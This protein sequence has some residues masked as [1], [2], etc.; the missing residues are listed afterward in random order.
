MTLRTFLPILIALSASVACAT[1][2]EPRVET[3]DVSASGV[4]GSS[5]SSTVS[6]GGGGGSP[7][8]EAVVRQVDATY[9]DFEGG[10]T[11]VVRSGSPLC[12]WG[13]DVYGQLADGDPSVSYK[14]VSITA[15][16]TPVDRLAVGELG[17][18]CA[19]GSDRAVYCWGNNVHGAAGIGA[20]SDVVGSPAHVAELGHEVVALSAGESACAIR[21]GGTLWCWGYS[22]AGQLGNGSKDPAFAPTQVVDLPPVTAVSTRAGAAC[23][24]DEAGEVW[25]WGNNAAGQLGIGFADYDEHTT[26][27][28]VETLGGGV[29]GISSGGGHVCARKNDDKLWCWGGNFGVVPVAAPDLAAGVAEAHAGY[30]FTC[31]LDREGAAWCWGEGANGQLGDGAGTASATPVQVTALGHDVVDLSSGTSSS[32]A[33][34]RDGSVWCWGLVPTTTEEASSYL[35]PTLLPDDFACSSETAPPL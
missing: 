14:A 34:K 33:T 11:C 3:D 9:N 8:V 10:N 32:C 2:S 20:A 12:C 13:S 16:A 28:K 7:A 5:A 26:P 1:S 29:V 18:I 35:E 4:G 19:L 24:V 27:A 23:A 21:E 30:G 22:G 6:S 31:V 17:F 25:C 15:L